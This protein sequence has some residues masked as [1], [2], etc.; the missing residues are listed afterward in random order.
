MTDD[1]PQLSEQQA[2]ARDAEKI[3][4]GLLSSRL[5]NDVK[6]PQERDY[7]L[8]YRI[9]AVT[10]GQLRG[11]EFLVQLKGTKAVPRGAASVPLSIPTTTLRYWKRKIL[12]IL[13]V[14]VDCTERKAYFCWF[15][16][17]LEVRNQQ[18]TQTIHIPT[19]PGGSSELTDLKLQ[20]SLEPFYAAFIEEL[21]DDMKLRFYRHLFSQANILSNLL[22]LTCMQQL[23]APGHLT[24]SDEGRAQLDEHR[25]RAVDLF[26]MAFTK[27]VI[28][29][30]LYF[31]AQQSLSL[32][33]NPFDVGLGSTIGRLFELHDSFAFQAGETPGFAIMMV[34]PERRLMSLPEI[35][36]LFGSIQEAL[37]GPLLC[38]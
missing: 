11:C 5:W 1:Y 3:F 10:D 2:I 28:D 33:T 9:E 4:E 24:T 16:K 15:D 36:S 13:V 21:A 30:R 29:L 23:F 25:Q 26:F 27:F 37:R 14:L 8:D 12:P 17:T 31:G 19:D 35:A 6:V 22:L 38:R 7:G 20:L 32:R 18:L 34:N